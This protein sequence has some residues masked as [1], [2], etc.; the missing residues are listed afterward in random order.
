MKSIRSELDDKVDDS[1]IR[2]IDGIIIELEI[3]QAEDT[4]QYDS[5]RVLKLLGCAMELVPSIGKLVEYLI[6]LGK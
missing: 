2:R 5:G 1:V 6:E 4:H 3:L